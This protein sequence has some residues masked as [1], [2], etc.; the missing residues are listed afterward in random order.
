MW[1]LRGTSPRAGRRAWPSLSRRCHQVLAARDVATARAATGRPPPP[2]SGLRARSA[3]SSVC[4]SPNSLP[5]GSLQ[6]ENQ[7]M[8][9][10]GV[11]SPA[12]PP[13]SLTRAAPALTSSTSKYV[14]V[15]RAGS[16]GAVDRA[17]RVLREPGHVV[18]AR[19]ARELLELPAEQAAPELLGLG[20]I[21]RGD[22]EVHHL[23]CHAAPFARYA[24]PTATPLSFNTTTNGPRSNRQ[25]RPAA[26]GLEVEPRGIEPLTFSDAMPDALP[27]ELRPQE[28]SQ[29]SLKSKSAAQL[30]PSLWLF[31][32]G[33]SRE[34]NVPTDP[35]SHRRDG[36]RTVEA[37]VQYAAIASISDAE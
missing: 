12:S 5:S 37:S 8:P 19:R 7:P 24:W 23:A 31:R 3:L 35:E 36:R 28:R 17:A 33:A 15:R 18:P 13:S 32:H 6:I 27:A 2:R 16:V 34:L 22:L 11:G 20:G 30:T 9:G 25:A 10:T 1:R 21:A 4:Q 29:S 26:A 14:R